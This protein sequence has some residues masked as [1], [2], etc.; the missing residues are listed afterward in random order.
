LRQ[1]TEAV[2]P[3]SLQT[4]AFYRSNGVNLKDTPPERLAA[5]EEWERMHLLCYRKQLFHEENWG[6]MQPAQE[7]ISVPTAILTET[8]TASAAEDFLMAFRSGK[9]EA[10]QVGRGTAGSTGQPL[11]QGLPFGGQFGIC[12]IHMPWPEEVWKN[13]IEPDIWVEPTIEDVIRNEDR[14]LKTAVEYL[15]GE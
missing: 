1:P 12:T 13:G 8:E 15:G 4:I 9:G 3:R 6:N 10:V 11:I 5:L 2:R 14:A 7:I